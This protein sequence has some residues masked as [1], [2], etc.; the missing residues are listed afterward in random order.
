MTNDFNKGLGDKPEILHKESISKFTEMIPR[1]YKVQF[2]NDSH[3]E[4]DNNQYEMKIGRLWVVEDLSTVKGGML[5]WN[6]PLKLRHFSS[7]KYLSVKEVSL[8]KYSSDE[9]GEEDKIES[10]EDFKAVSSLFL[11]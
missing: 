3:K 11:Y 8:R 4:I 7:G 1:N 10:E 5:A 9:E 6:Q 2:F